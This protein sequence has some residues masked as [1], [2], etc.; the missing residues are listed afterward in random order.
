MFVN[1][2]YKN[3]LLWN[4]TKTILEQTIKKL[5]QQMFKH[6]I[7]TVYHTFNDEYFKPFPA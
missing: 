2:R 3:Q 1:D 4:V 7:Y 5:C 6:F